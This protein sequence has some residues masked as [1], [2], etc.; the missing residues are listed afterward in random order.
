[1]NLAYLVGAP[2]I[3]TQGPSGASAHVRSI[4]RALR[5]EHEVSCVA[6]LDVDRRG[7]FGEE[8]HAVTTGA[9]GW[10]SWLAPWREL[11]EVWAA[12][13]VAAR[14][15]DLEL[16][17]LIE[18]HSLFSDAGW[19]VGERL[20]IPWVLEV[21]APPVAE[22]RRYEEIRQPRWADAWERDVLQA[23]PAIAAVS[24]WLARWLRE[25]VG[26]RR[27]EVVSNGV[28]PWVGDRV[29][30]RTIIGDVPEP[31]V[32]FAGSPRHWPGSE[33]V[34]SVARAL[35]GTAVT[36]GFGE[37]EGAK[38][39]G[40]LE[41][42]SLADVVAAFDV[43]LA[44]YRA[45]VPPWCSP[46]KVRLYRSQGVP[47]VA[48]DVFDCR[49]LVGDAGAVVDPADDDAFVDAAR[50]WVGRRVAP[51]VRSWRDVGRDLVGLLG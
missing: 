41:G 40:F 19:R 2:G 36:L 6:A 20:G 25:E 33:R 7:R 12:R 44:P 21:N 38:S 49:S 17:G 45:D 1:M 14:A 27:V 16:D 4:V 3:P 31:I 13:R 32:G 50:S 46:L 29:R 28:D 30:G 15:I 23:A 5:E 24:E 39:L 35:G 10:P 43:A 42:Q 9:P 8:L 22:R 34:A 47:V 48:S 18:R 51:S 11:R 37:I 26:A